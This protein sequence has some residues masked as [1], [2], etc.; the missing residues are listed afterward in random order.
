MH[1]YMQY[2]QHSPIIY[3]VLDI[4]CCNNIHIIFSLLPSA[5][6]IYI[7]PTVDKKIVFYNKYVKIVNNT[8]F[9]MTGLT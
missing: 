2:A 1:A 7:Y 8:R 6:A 5:L 4:A 3:P 9:S